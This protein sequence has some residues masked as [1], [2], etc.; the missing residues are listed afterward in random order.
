MGKSIPRGGNSQW[1]I[2]EA[3]KFKEQQGGQV[4][5]EER[6]REKGVRGYVLGNRRQDPMRSYRP[7]CGCRLFFSKMGNCC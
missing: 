5:A 6:E 7:M 1:K 2:P 3:G 4:A